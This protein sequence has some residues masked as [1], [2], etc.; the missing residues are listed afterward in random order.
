M[1]EGKNQG[2]GGF[3]GPEEGKVLSIFSKPAGLRCGPVETRSGKIEK[4]N[5]NGRL[6]SWIRREWGW[7]TRRWRIF[8]RSG[9]R[10]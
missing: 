4:M 10:K 6:P 3:K 9:G 1:K 5:L 7:L 8:K 2:S